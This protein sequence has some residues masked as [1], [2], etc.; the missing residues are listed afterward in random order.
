MCSFRIIGLFILASFFVAPVHAQKKVYNKLVWQDDFLKNGLPDSTKWSYDV[1]HGCP[2]ICGW[3]NNEI[4]Y[5]TQA[6]KENARVENGCLIIEARKEKFA[7]ANYTSARLVTKNKGD[8]KYGRMVIRAQIPTGKGLWP[9]G[10]ILPT[11]KVYG[12]W[13][14]SGEVD[15]LE[16]VGFAPDSAFGSVH[17]GRYNGMIG[18]QKSASLIVPN[19]SS[20]FHDYEIVWTPEKIDF[21]IDK[22]LYNSFKN[23]HTDSDAWPFDQTFHLILNIA[24]GG[25]LGGKHGIDDAI[26]PAQMKVDFVKVFQ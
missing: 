5:Y 1:G 20:Q 8:W 17:T 11:H 21:Y 7:D 16:A 10:W 12:E 4:Q 18:T 24:I 3:G 15:I 25:N 13:P 26:F 23:E 19:L 2:K 14:K 6:R 9:A 22:K